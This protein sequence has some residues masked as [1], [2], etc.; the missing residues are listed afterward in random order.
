MT[1]KEER[2]HAIDSAVKRAGGLNK[3]AAALGISNQAVTAWRRRGFVPFERA[4][5]VEYLYGVSRVAMMLPETAAAYLAPPHP[6]LD[7]L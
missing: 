6:S 7:I 1:T 5:T 2:R 3:F 4:T